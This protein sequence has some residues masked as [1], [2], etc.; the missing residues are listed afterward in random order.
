M[1]DFEKVK[2]FGGFHVAVLPY[3]GSLNPECLQGSLCEHRPSI[4]GTPMFQN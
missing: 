4:A 2:D 3:M 1:A